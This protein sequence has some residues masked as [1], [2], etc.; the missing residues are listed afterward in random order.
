MLYSTA[1]QL[2]NFSV[3]VLLVYVGC[4]SYLFL[5]LYMALFHVV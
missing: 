5:T 4:F 3:V 1:V 2:F